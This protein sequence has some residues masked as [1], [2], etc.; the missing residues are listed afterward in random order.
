MGADP[1]S[2]LRGLYPYHR[3]DGPRHP[4]LLYELAL[5]PGTSP[6]GWSIRENGEPIGEFCPTGRLAETLERRITARA[7]DRQGGW[8]LLHAAAA[9]FR[10]GSVVL[11]GA[12]GAGKTTLALALRERGAKIL[13]DDIVQLHPVRGTIRAYPRSFL[14]KEGSGDRDTRDGDPRMNVRLAAYRDVQGA[15]ETGEDLPVGWIV[16]PERR[17]GASGVLVPCAETEALARMLGL[18]GRGSTGRKETFGALAALVR[19]S[20]CYRM[21]YPHAMKGASLLLG[22]QDVIDA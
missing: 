18:A 21:V 5:S 8:I 14:L 15:P 6:S 4:D 9:A 7:I 16:F 2:S 13:G 22:L 3:T 10:S 20:A 19:G 17:G 1:R 12:S 11:P